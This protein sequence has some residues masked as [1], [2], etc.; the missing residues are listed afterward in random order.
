[1]TDQTLFTRS[2]LAERW[3]CSTKTIDRL[4]RMGRLAWINISGRRGRRALIRF[5]LNGIEK[6][7][8]T[9]EQMAGADN[10]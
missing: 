5:P 8:Q 10:D 9:T 1:M 7:E 2:E 4:K 3:A 6:F